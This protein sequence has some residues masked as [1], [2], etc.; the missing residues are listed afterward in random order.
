[1]HAVRVLQKCLSGV[2]ASM[3]AARA[4]V[5]L[6]AVAALLLGRRL[7]LMDLARAW[8]GAQ[9]VRAPLKRLDR[10]LSNRR[11]A[12]EAKPLYAAM[13]HWLIH[14]QPRP[15]IIVDWS[16]LK[17]NGSLHLLRAAIPIGGRTLTVFEAIYPERKKNSPPV[18][19]QF[20]RRLKTLL[21]AHVK[22][23][24]VTD[25][26]FRGP[27]FRAVTELGWD[28]IGRLR[29][30]T[31]VKL[32]PD[33][34]WIPNRSLHAKASQAPKRFA[35]A[36]I[37]KER[38]WSCDLVLV[39]RPRCGRTLLPPRGRRS[40]DRRPVKA[41]Q[42]N[43]EPWLL[44]TSLTSFS[45]RQIV[46]LYVKRMQIEESFRDLKCDRFG[47][48]FHYSQTRSVERLAILLLLH[49]LA[50]FLAWLTALAA[51]TP[52]AVRYGGVVS[53]RSRRHYSLL[54]IGWEILRQ[55]WTPISL[56]ALQNSFTHPPRW[57][58]Q[59]MELP[60]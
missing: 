10:L 51:D 57:W 30:R 18:E 49:A 13:A 42:A 9:Y 24:I 48:A 2:F 29:H 4:R 54:R 58:R 37:V 26:G 12:Q 28:Y 39:R 14:H 44:A 35:H 5:L 33:D 7:I 52:H 25:A 60:E 34:A 27:W 53:R 46:A 40:L 6:G 15:V 31:G 32:T 41:E 1:M 3:H 20:L 16:E 8:P 23:I 11:L 56:A 59:E 47:C 17:A 21:P 55:R 22:P 43:R 19:R 50:T 36:C 45:D 38:P